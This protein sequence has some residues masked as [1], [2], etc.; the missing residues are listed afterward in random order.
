M[1]GVV[2]APTKRKFGQISGTDQDCASLI[3]HIEK[4]KRA[5]PRLRDLTWFDE[6]FAELL[7]SVRVTDSLLQ[8]RKASDVGL[9][10]LVNGNWVPFRKSLSVRDTIHLRSDQPGMT[11]A[12]VWL[13]THYLN[14]GDGAKTF[15]TPSREY[16]RRV[17]AGTQ[18]PAARAAAF[19]IDPDML[20]TTLRAYAQRMPFDRAHFRTSFPAVV[21]TTARAITDTIA[22]RL[23]P[24]P[25][26]TAGAVAAE[27]YF[28]AALCALPNN[29]HAPVAIGNV[30]KMTKRASTAARTTSAPSC[31]SRT[32]RIIIWTTLSSLEAAHRLLPAQGDIRRLLA[33]GNVA[34]GRKDE[35]R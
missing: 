26:Q 3:G 1:V 6:G 15:G 33:P 23:G 32:L 25:V 4:D 30:H 24:L 18:S 17:E 19:G 16:L 22:A 35:A 28:D 12:Q 9:I 7:S 13:L 27:R 11:Y 29:A 5:F 8:Y 21:M 2:G 20:E 31:L 10:W 34:A 14:I